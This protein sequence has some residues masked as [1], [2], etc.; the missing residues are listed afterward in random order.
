MNGNGDEIYALGRAR[1][2]FYNESTKWQATLFLQYSALQDHVH[3]LDP[4]APEEATIPLASLPND[5]TRLSLGIDK[6]AHAEFALRSGQAHDALATLHM[7]IRAYNSGVDCK[8]DNLRQRAMTR[9]K[10]NS[11]IRTGEE[12]SCRT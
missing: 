10:F 2:R 6:L 4:D 12:A 5:Q 3:R 8:R 7:E 9:R 1:V 11:C